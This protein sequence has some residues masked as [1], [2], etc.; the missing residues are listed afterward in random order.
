VA[1]RSDDQLAA[2]RAPAADVRRR[3]DLRQQVERYTDW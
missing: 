3:F 2:R 1:G